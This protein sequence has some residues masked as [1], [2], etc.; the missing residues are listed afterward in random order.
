[1]NR[2]L[3]VK[4]S[5]WLRDSQELF[6][7]DTSNL[8]H[9]VLKLHDSG[10]I[11]RRGNEIFCQAELSS[12]SETRLLR[13]VENDGEFLVC[14]LKE[15][16]IGLVIK[17]CKFQDSQGYRLVP[18]DLLKLGKVSLRVKQTSETPCEPS[19]FDECEGSNNT[20]VTC[21]ICFRTHSNRIDP[22]LSLCYCSGT[23]ALTHLRCLQRWA[24]SRSVQKVNAHCIS[25]LWKNLECDICRQ[26]LPLDFVF[27]GNAYNLISVP[28][29]NHRYLMLEDFRRDKYKCI[30]HVVNPE[31][32][33]V[34]IGRSPDSDLK[35]NDVSVSRSHATVHCRDSRFFLS[36]NG[37]KFGTL[38][39]TSKPMS[40]VPGRAVVVQVNRSRFVFSMRSRN[41]MLR[42]LECCKNNGA[43]EPIP[44]GR[45]EIPAEEQSLRSHQSRFSE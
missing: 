16:C 26:D 7:Y 28:A 39:L 44:R 40:V 34:L 27:E 36:D 19:S 43:V 45:T 23:M 2:Y 25:Y 3:E 14:P 35:I 11:I 24:I 29:P 30:V 15:D 41:K 22:L 13:I 18:G 9:D 21:R 8:Q 32:V 5:T 1:M 4:A 33:P 10:Y 20:D 31:L 37:S 42:C 17:D 38:V 6:D 12:P